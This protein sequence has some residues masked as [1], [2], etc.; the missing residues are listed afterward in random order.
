MLTFGWSASKR[1]ML[2]WIVGTEYDQTWNLRSTVD[3]AFRAVAASGNVVA[4]AAMMPSTNSARTGRRTPLF[5]CMDIPLLLLERLIVVRC[6]RRG[7]LLSPPQPVT[8]CCE[9]LLAGRFHIVERRCI[10]RR[11]RSFQWA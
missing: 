11:P 4:S 1:L 8:S 9:A 2:L 6:Q 3:G 5:L 7:G 10:C